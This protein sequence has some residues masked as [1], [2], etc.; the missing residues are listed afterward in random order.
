MPEQRKVKSHP[1]TRDMPLPGHY[2]VLT[3]QLNLTRYHPANTIRWT[4]IVR[5]PSEQ[6]EVTRVV[7][8][9]TEDEEK[10]TQAMLDAVSAAM[11]EMLWLQTGC[12]DN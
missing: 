12:K 7:Q 11:T 5:E 1:I 4:L 2:P 6:L 8:G 3:M 9:T 10:Q